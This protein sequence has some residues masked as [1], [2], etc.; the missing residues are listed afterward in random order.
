VKLTGRQFQVAKL[1]ASGLPNKAIARELGITEGTVKLH[2]NSILARLGIHSRVM[3]AVQWR[4]E[5]SSGSS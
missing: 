3:L 1:A 2:M 5:T 4:A